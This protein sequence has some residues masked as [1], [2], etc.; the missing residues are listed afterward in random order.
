MRLYCWNLQ[1][2]SPVAIV[3]RLLVWDGEEWWWGGKREKTQPLNEKIAS[4]FCEWYL[5]IHTEATPACEWQDHTEKVC[6][7]LD[8]NT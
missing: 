2:F 1:I 3:Q 7:S 8:D 6:Y 5:C 4:I